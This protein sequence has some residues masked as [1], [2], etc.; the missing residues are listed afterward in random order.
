MKWNAWFSRNSKRRQEELEYREK[1]FIY[2]EIIKAH[3]E[4]L[5]A[6]QA[7]QEAVGKDEVDFAIYTLEAAERRYQIHLKEAKKSN[8][9]LGELGRYRSFGRLES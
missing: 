4:W 6:H 1:E 8:L 5:R 2:G 3:K 9:H 7:F